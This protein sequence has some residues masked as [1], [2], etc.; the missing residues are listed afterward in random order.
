MAST[1]FFEQRRQG[2]QDC[3]FP[4]LKRNERS[5]YPNRNRQRA[6][7]RAVGDCV[8][9][10]LSEAKIPG[11]GLCKSPTKSPLSGGQCSARMADGRR[12]G[13]RMQ[14]GRVWK[15]RPLHGATLAEQA[16]GRGK[17]NETRDRCR[18]PIAYAEARAKAE[19]KLQLRSNAPTSAASIAERRPIGRS[20]ATRRQPPRGTEAE[21]GADGPKKTG[22][23]VY[24]FEKCSAKG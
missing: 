5:E 22:Q 8:K 14:S 3:V 9:K 15:R 17:V 24:V 6:R 23:R 2:C 21:W 19:A 1:P 4:R 11:G 16:R 12:K 13:R 10:E 18:T 20:E 7:M